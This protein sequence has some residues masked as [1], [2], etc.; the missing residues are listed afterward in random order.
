VHVASAL[1]IFR[2]P[3]APTASTRTVSQNL[4]T[5]P[6]GM[7]SCA[8]NAFDEPTSSLNNHRTE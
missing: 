5:S 3:P 6:A 2:I 8:G 4:I 7:S 1:P